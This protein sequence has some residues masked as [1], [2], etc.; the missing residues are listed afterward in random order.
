MLWRMPVTT[1]FFQLRALGLLLVTALRRALRVSERRH[2]QGAQG[3]E[4]IVPPMD[5]AHRPRKPRRD[6]AAALLSTHHSAPYPVL[7]IGTAKRSARSHIVVLSLP[8]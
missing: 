6:I 3:Q 4:R 2:Q 5:R 8:I 7:V 1:T